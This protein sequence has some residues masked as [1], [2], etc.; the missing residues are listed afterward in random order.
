MLHARRIVLSL[1]ALGAVL[2]IC[3]LAPAALAGSEAAAGHPAVGAW[4]DAWRAGTGERPSY[5]KG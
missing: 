3:L 2:F 4:L 5:V 1:R